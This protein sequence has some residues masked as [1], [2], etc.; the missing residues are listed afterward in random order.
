MAEACNPGTSIE[1]PDRC[2]FRWQRRRDVSC[3]SRYAK[4]LRVH[5]IAVLCSCQGG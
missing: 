3:F 2:C 1:T 5:S 4:G